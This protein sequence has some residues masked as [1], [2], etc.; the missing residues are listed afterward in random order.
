MNEPIQNNTLSNST[1]DLHEDGTWLALLGGGQLGLM[2][3]EAAQKLGLRVAAID[4]DK[5]APLASRADRFWAVP[6]NHTETLDLMVALCETATVEFENIPFPTLAYLAGK[7]PLR[8]SADAIAT[9]QDRAKEKALFSRCGLPTAPYVV[10]ENEM[11]LE[12]VNSTF[13]PARLK[14]LRL[15]YDGKGQVAVASIHQ[16]SEAW[17]RLNH[18]PSI[19]ERHIALKGEISV[20]IARDVLGRIALWSV[21]ENFHQNGILD[22]TLAPARIPDHLKD[23]AYAAAQKVA[24]TMGYVGVLC[25]EFFIDENETLLLNEIAPRPHNSGHHTIESCVTSQFE[26]QARIAA[27]LP[28]GD[29]TQKKASVM[30]NL[31]GDLWFDDHTLVPREPDWNAILRDCPHTTLRLYGKKDARRGR[32][33]GHV[34]CCAEHLPDAIRTANLIRARLSQTS[35]KLAPIPDAPALKPKKTV[36][37]KTKA[38]FH[39]SAL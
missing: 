35:M 27:A 38:R 25:V 36:A 4:P 14:T 1:T 15:G 18:T 2:F 5:N 30:I 29:T 20:L 13:F 31:L 28:L 17:T 12:R 37:A 10:L 7:L 33:M 22:V 34:T 9:A 6:Y 21:S 26:Q 11:D 19:L 16:L 3:C 32:K 23:H 8:P 24:E 39:K